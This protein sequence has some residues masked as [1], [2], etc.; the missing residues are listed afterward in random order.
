MYERNTEIR[1]MSASD[2]RKLGE[3]LDLSNDWKLVAGIIPKDIT[4][5]L[6]D[7][8]QTKYNNE[9]I[10]LIENVSVNQ[11]RSPTEILLDEWG[12][13]GKMRPTMEVLLNV[14]VKA[15]LL[16]AAD[17]VA[18]NFLNGKCLQALINFC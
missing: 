6:D 17:L 3:I 16:R 13:S 2:V 12:T 7:D 9:H 18:L 5:S 4:A 8:Y 10:R 1:K 14:L 11:R 15:Q